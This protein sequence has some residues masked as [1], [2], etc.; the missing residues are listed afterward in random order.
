M[1]LAT[2][3]TDQPFCSYQ[4]NNVAM[5]QASGLEDRIPGSLPLRLTCVTTSPHTGTTSMFSVRTGDKGGRLVPLETNKLDVL[6]EHM[7]RRDFV[8]R[9]GLQTKRHRLKSSAEFAGPQLDAAITEA[10]ESARCLRYR[11]QGSALRANTNHS[12][13]SGDDRASSE[14]LPSIC[15]LRNRL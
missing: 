14:R 15:E 11:R 13:S 12:E 1:T 5:L 2:N 9:A 6:T 8:G 3:F 10:M 7:W 4:R